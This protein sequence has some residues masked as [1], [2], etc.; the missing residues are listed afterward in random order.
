MS[1]NKGFLSDLLQS[2]SE[3]GREL[4]ARARGRT[5][6]NGAIRTENLIELC[7]HLLS[8][9]GEASGVALAGEIIEAYRALKTGERV[10]FFEALAHR[11]GPDRERLLHAARNYIADTSEDT[12]AELHE[13]SEPRRQEIV[14]RINLASN[15]TEALVAMRADLLDA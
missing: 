10:A 1:A 2:I 8:G 12:E 9:R 6:P 3:R 14:R 11:F 15:G 4:I 5:R 13:A 7:E